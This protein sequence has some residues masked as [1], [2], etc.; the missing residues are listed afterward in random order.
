MKS[1]SS[2][3]PARG[4]FSRVRSVRMGESRLLFVSGIAASKETPPGA[5]EQAEIIFQTID[6]LLRDHGASLRDI[7]K[8]TAFLADI[9]DY[10]AYNSVRNRIFA[11][12]PA[13]PASSTVE[14]RLVER[15]FRVEVEAI[16][17]PGLAGEGD[18]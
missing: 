1:E 15:K 14:A 12:H 6:N 2:L 18:A 5:G 16:A 17:I 4:N 7:V 11:D 8:I 10:Q 3:P 13:P 9:D